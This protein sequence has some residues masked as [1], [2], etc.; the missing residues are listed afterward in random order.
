MRVQLPRLCTKYPEARSDVKQLQV[1]PKPLRRKPFRPNVVG[2]GNIAASAWTFRQDVTTAKGAAKPIGDGSTD[3]V[4]GNGG[5]VKKVILL[6]LA[7][8]ASYFLGACGSS[9]SGGGAGG[10]GSQIAT[11]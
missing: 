10:G 6:A 11:H 4:R 7:F 3:D 9:N 5:I 2:L 8:S 1:I